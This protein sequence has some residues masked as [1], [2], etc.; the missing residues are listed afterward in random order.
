MSKDLAANR[1]AA[2]LAYENAGREITQA[3][4]ILN[5]NL[6]LAA[7]TLGVLLT[8]LGAGELFGHDIVIKIAGHTVDRAGVR[9]TPTLAGVPRLSDV[10]V[11]LLA[12]AIPLLGRFFI[13][14]TIGYQQLIR[15]NLIQRNAW[16]YLSGDADWVLP[17]MTMS[18]YVQRWRSPASACSLFKG[19]FKYGFAW[20]FALATA[21]LTW[22]LVTAPGVVPRALGLAFVVVGV[23][24]EWL[25][26]RNAKHFE[27]PS[28]K[29]RCDLRRLESQW[30]IAG[31][32]T[33]KGHGKARP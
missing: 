1:A 3:F 21:A 2:T 22:G 5:A 33:N 20:V 30:N 10:S 11:L 15:F 6:T 18:I 19:S 31:Q 28:K 29:E 25:T 17:H 23:G 24:A 12:A 32:A 8:V 13:R 26:L 9:E 14:A 16:H 27:L 7:G 4:S